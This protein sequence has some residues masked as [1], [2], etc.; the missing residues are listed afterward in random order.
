MSCPINSR[1]RDATV[2]KHFTVKWGDSKERKYL[3]G[4]TRRENGRKFC[5]LCYSCLRHFAVVILFSFLWRTRVNSRTTQRVTAGPS[6]R[7]TFIQYSKFLHLLW[8][9]LGFISLPQHSKDFKSSSGRHR[10]FRLLASPP[11]WD[12]CKQ[13][14]LTSFTMM[15]PQL[16]CLI[17]LFTLFAHRSIS[18]LLFNYLYRLHKLLL[19]LKLP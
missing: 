11:K 17:V 14:R 12:Q 6:R 7:V 19:A 9:R 4:L 2:T 18:S 13:T 1:M 15:V 10:V 8:T 16:V 5:T 3:S